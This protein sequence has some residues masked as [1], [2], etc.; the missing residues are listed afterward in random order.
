MK[1]KLYLYLLILIAFTIPLNGK[2]NSI[3]IGLLVLYWLI[4]GNLISK[5][6][7]VLN[8]N[9]SLL[10]MS[11]F[12]IQVLGLIYSEN[13]S[14]GLRQLEKKAS[15]LIL[16][17]I[18][19]SSPKL[20]YRESLIVVLSFIVSCFLVLSF[21]I[22]KTVYVHGTLFNLPSIT[23]FIDETIG[24]HHAYSGLYLVFSLSFLYHFINKYWFKME[25]YFKLFSV[26]F[27]LV[28]FIY[29]IILGARMALF[30][31]FLILFIQTINNI[32]TYKNYKLLYIAGF[33]SIIGIGSILYLPSTKEKVHQLLFLRGTYHPLTPRLIQWE[34]CFKILEENNAWILGVGTGD[35]SNYLLDCYQKKSFWGYLHKYNAHNEYLE[36]MVALGLFGLSLL[37]ASFFFPLLYS[38]KIKNFYYVYFILIFMIVCLSET[39]L[40]RQNGIVFFAFFNSLLFFSIYNEQNS[41]KNALNYNNY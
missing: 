22:I 10:F 23:E 30:I 7:E 31:T 18:I 39:V 32:I 2:I 33:A 21:G 20:K 16:P 35:V 26:L 19:V 34:C 15:L 12:I 38:I 28:I 36:E 1:D 27:F 14:Y 40:N 4:S 29:L 5:I 25:I 17:L 13:L 6:K 3:S 9:Y 24:I 8:N 11:I 41:K 37:L